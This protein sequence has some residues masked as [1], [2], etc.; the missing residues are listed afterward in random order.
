[1]SRLMLRKTHIESVL[2]LLVIIGLGTL[3]LGLQS[4]VFADRGLLGLVLGI[5]TFKGSI[6]KK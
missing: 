2:V 4:G 1:M 3:S 6:I 5:L